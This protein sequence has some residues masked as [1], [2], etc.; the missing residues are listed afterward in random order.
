MKENLDCSVPVIQGEDAEK[1]FRH[2]STC[3]IAVSSHKTYYSEE[4]L[5]EVRES[6][7]FIQS[8]LKED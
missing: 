5:L 4:R 1:F 6:Y 3:F 8:L 7:T 2:F